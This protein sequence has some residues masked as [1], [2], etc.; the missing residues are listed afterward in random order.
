LL[1]RARKPDLISVVCLLL[2]TQ[3]YLDGVTDALRTIVG[4]FFANRR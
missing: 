2:V 4:Y 1:V 3:Q